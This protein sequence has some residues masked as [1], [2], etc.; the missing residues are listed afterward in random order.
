M[1]EFHGY[2]IKVA[3]KWGIE[4]TFIT[5]PDMPTED[6]IRSIRHKQHIKNEAKVD[7]LAKSSW[8]EV[9]QAKVENWAEQYS[10]LNQHFH[11]VIL[12]N[13]K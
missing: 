4:T 3:A 6:M 1:E 12:Q 11:V 9:L 10:H 13:T 5:K 8:S 2:L 7:S